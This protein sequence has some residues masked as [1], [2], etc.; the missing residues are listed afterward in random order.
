MSGPRLN[1]RRHWLARQIRLLRCEHNHSSEQ[2]ATHR[3]LPRQP[4]SALEKD[5][6]FT[7]HRHDRVSA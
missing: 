5:L 1:M 4:L 6:I 3:R 7:V 2:L